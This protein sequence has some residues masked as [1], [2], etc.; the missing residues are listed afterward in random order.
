MKLR[1]KAHQQPREVDLWG[2]FYTA[3]LL[4]VTK[5][6]RE[7]SHCLTHQYSSSPSFCKY[8]SGVSCMPEMMLE[9]ED[10]NMAMTSFT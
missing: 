9:L 2:A 8:L 6:A 7:S 4:R 10:E 3:L 1:N 5:N